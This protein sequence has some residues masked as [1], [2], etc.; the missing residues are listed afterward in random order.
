MN[1]RDLL[2]TA[3]KVTAGAV[4]GAALAQTGAPTVFARRADSVTTLNFLTG[5]A[6]SD[7]A[8][9]QAIVTAF[10]KAN[11]DINVKMQI[12]GTWAQFYTKLL[13][14]L[15]AGN[16][17]EVFTT[18]IQE[19]LYFQDKQLFLQLDDLFGPS[20]P[21]SDFAPTPM[22]YAGYKGH[23]YGMPLDMHGWAFYTNPTLLKKAGLPLRAPADGAE[24]VD[25]ARKLTIDKN[26]NN[27]KSARFDPSHVVQ[28]GIATSWDAPPTF[29]STLWSFGGNTISA[30]G[31]TALFNTPAMRDAVNFWG[32]LIFK[33][34]AC[35][36]PA[37]YGANGAWG[38]YQNNAL[39]MVPDGNWMRSW[40]AAHPKVARKA[41]FM[42]KYGKTQQ[43]W[44][45]GH[46]IAAPASLP[47]DKK[48]A[49]YK[50]MHWLSNHGVQWTETAGH[51]PARISQRTSSKVMSLWP[52][53]V[54]GPELAGIGHIEQPSTVF[55]DVQDAYVAE[56]DAAWNGTKSISAALSSAQSRV[57]RA[58]SGQ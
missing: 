8:A 5:L 55:F 35:N 18:H 36:K 9:M 58:L 12:I 54:Y 46:V 22:K 47:N 13:P 34:H 21:E 57:Q 50:F 20:L 25:W 43:A 53:Q 3:G 2:T 30:D 49:V 38:A 24:L 16:A 10:N 37:G 26:G 51:I 14:T 40:F 15:T 29:L 17:P 48:P 23:M 6:G 56:I 28:Y 33:Y 11:P 27:G 52:Q 1:R 31:K 19:M 45:S 39:A 41:N 7:G 32:D 42:P 44:M 4:A